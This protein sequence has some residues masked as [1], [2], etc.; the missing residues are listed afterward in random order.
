MKYYKQIRKPTLP[1]SRPHDRKDKQ[2]KEMRKKI[3]PPKKSD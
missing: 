1:K 2:K 3:D